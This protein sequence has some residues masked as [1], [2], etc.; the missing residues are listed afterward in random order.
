MFFRPLVLL[1][2]SLIGIAPA[3]GQASSPSSAP[4][5]SHVERFSTIEARAER[6]E[7]E[8][9]EKLIANPNDAPALNLR[10]VAR[11]FLGRYPEAAK[12]L[13]HAVAL[14]PDNSTYQAN[15]GSALWKLGQLEDAISTERVA[16]KLDDNNFTAHYQLG[17]FLLR[18]GERGRLAET[19]QHLR[20]AI[21]IDPRQYD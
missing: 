7:S 18:L 12:D 15:L 2:T 3:L 8:A 13:R 19:A 16:L 4:T 1:A 5:R 17:R 6:V 10:G 21:Q 11:L 20:R 14:K 9:N